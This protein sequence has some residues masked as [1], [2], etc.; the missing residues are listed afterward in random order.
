MLEV[1]GVIAHPEI[2]L[3]VPAASKLAVAD[4]ECDRHLVVLVQGLV[5]ALALVGLHLDV[6]RGRERDEAARCSEDGEG[7]EQHDWRRAAVLWVFRGVELG[8][9]RCGN[10]QVARNL[11]GVAKR[12]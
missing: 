7:R 3:Q 2:N 11:A 5:E 9:S 12:V 6:V 4:L 8:S 1:H 10:G